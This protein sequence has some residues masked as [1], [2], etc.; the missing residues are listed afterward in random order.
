MSSMDKK[1]NPTAKG[2]LQ[3]IVRKNLLHSRLT[4]KV[5]C[6]TLRHSF[7]THLLEDGVDLVTTKELLGHSCKHTLT[8]T[9]IAFMI[10]K[11]PLNPL[12]TFKKTKK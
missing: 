8:Y 11:R 12:D 6:H 1:V 7:A 9:H 5:S 2:T 4:K 10:R 3:Y